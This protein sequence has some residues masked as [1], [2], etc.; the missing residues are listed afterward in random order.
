MVGFEWGPG[1]NSHGIATSALPGEGCRMRWLAIAAAV[2]GMTCAAR[3]QFPDLTITAIDITPANP[4]PGQTI[5][6]TVTAAN[7]G[8]SPPFD[9]V[10]C[11]LYYNSSGVPVACNSDQQQS[12][13]VPFPENSERLFHFTMQYPNAG[14]FRMWAWIDGCEPQVDEGDENNNT[15]SR[16]VSVGIGD[17]TIDSVGP[18]TPDPIP[19]EMVY[20]RIVV[21]NTGPAIIDQIWQVGVVFQSTEPTTCVFA[22]NSEPFVG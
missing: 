10:I 11:Y 6:V 16:D 21:R 7:I 3:G 1:M 22:Q 15:L 14:Q 13:K 5:N 18:N 20:T 19:G 4:A 2:V 8:N 12:L 17:L 9:S